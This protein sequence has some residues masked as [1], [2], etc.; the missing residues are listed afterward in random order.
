MENQAMDLSIRGANGERPMDPVGPI[1]YHIVKKGLYRRAHT[2]QGRTLKNFVAFC[3]FCTAHQALCATFIIPLAF[4]G[5]RAETPHDVAGNHPLLGER[6]LPQQPTR[7]LRH[8]RVKLAQ[9]IAVPYVPDNMKGPSPVDHT[10]QLFGAAS[11]KE[12]T[13]IIWTLKTACHGQGEAQAGQ[14]HSK[15]RGRST[16]AV[17]GGRLCGQGKN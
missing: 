4:G 5:S 15:G 17:R 14:A 16:T 10:M 1:V 13:G 3:L 8:G 2:L 6:E 11:V 9:S 12:E 7:F